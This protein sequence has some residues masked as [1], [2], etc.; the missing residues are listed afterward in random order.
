VILDALLK[1][2]QACCD[3]RLLK[4]KAAQQAKVGSAKLDRLMELLP[5]LLD[6]GRRVLLFSQFT[7]MLALIGQRLAAE[8][9]SHVL[10]MRRH[11]GPVHPGA[12]LP[13]R[14]GAAVPDQPEGRR[15]RAEPDR[16]RHGD[17]L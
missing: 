8:K 14:R 13:A 4:L 17:P 5:Q 11:G 9:Q 2:R 15:R 16:G 6:E 10:L 1:L 3:P 7:S 12:S